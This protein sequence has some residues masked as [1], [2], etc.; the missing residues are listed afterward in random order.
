MNLKKVLGA[1][2]SAAALTA[3]MS[4]SAMAESA[5]VNLLP[6]DIS[7]VVCG[8][9]G[10]V[11]KDGSSVVFKAGAAD[12]SFTY[13]VNTQVDMTTTDYLYFGINATGGWDI[14]WAST[15]LNN[16]VNP[17]VSADFG[18]I[19]GKDANPGENQYGTLIEAGSYAPGD[20]EIGAAGAYTWND[21][22]PDDGIVTVTG[23]EIKVGAN[24]QV[25]LSALYF[26]DIDAAEA[27]PNAPTTNDGEAPAATTAAAPAAN[28]TDK[29]TKKSSNP[30]TGE[31]T[32]MVA[33]GIVL[34]VVSAGA[35]ALTM[36]K[37]AQ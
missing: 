35:V 4:M 37:K 5:T 19:F 36:K 32:A 31:S 30:S 11:E 23:I 9:G 25:T 16:D 7:A 3:T 21:N 6:A 22:L 15:G 28:N 12:T 26:G 24:S 34:A 1:V 29:T 13:A 17:G 33:S 27:T 18:N 8:E 2:L 14:K 10:T 20:V